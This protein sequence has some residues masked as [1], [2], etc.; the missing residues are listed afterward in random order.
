MHEMY[1]TESELIFLRTILSKLVKGSMSFT[2][3]EINFLRCEKGQLDT[4]LKKIRVELEV[5]D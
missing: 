3:S 2:E 5:M 4:I 1:F